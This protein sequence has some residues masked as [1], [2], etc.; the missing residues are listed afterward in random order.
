MDESQ[1]SERAKHKYNTALFFTEN[2]QIA[3]V[4][5]LVVAIW[6]VYGYWEMP[7][8]KDPV[9]P[10]RVATAVTPWP[11]T[12]AEKVEQLVTRQIEST[13]AENA[14]IHQP[15]PTTY[16]IK[17]LTLPGLSIVLIQLSDS[18]TNTERE[19]NNINLKLEGLN[20]SLPEGAGPIQFNSGF[21]DTAALLLTVASP[22]ESDVE[23]SL[24]AR[25]IERA[26]TAVRAG[27]ATGP[28]VSI[29]VALPRN[30][31]PDVTR[32]G[33]RLLKQ[34]MEKEKFGRDIRLLQ[35]PGFAGL[36]VQTNADDKTFSAFVKNFVPNVLGASRFQPDAWQPAFIRDP[37]NAQARLLAVRG[38]KY[39]YRDLDRYTDL[40][41]R[42]LQ[43]IP[44][45]TIIARSGVQ[46]EQIFLTY[47]QERLAALGVQPANIKQVLA[48]RNTPIPGGSIESGDVNILVEP[49]GQFTNESQLSDVIVAKSSAGSPVYLRSVAD[50]RRGYQTPPRFLNFY[51][52]PDAQGNWHRSRAISLA[53]QMRAGE[54]ISHFG[55]AVDEKLATVK[56]HLPEDLI[57]A[58]V[59]DQPLQ[60][61]QST[62]LFMTALYEAVILVVFVAF[63][64][65]WE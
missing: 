56:Q 13:V 10:V 48:A 62:N 27:A 7:K 38:D 59:S 28:R 45:V 15:D 63:L 50:I 16:G 43:T 14:N 60:S 22:K 25:S 8:R 29:V 21:S 46:Q 36:D 65:F 32:R 34:T 9:V 23:I 53:I 6:G 58:R 41:S 20:N 5:L 26:I 57:L 18:I 51:T 52:W 17:S 44:Q 30:V 37:G 55:A 11:G 64:G 47:S 61:K 19:F 40:I 24:R 3:W 54:Q 49:S 42:N 2:R 1:E 35:G 33:L 4:L 12:D 31:S 39:G